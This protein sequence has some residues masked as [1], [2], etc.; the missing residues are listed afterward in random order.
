MLNQSSKIYEALNH[1]EMSSVIRIFE[2]GLEI[3]KL[4]N[5][6]TNDKDTQAC[7]NDGEMFLTF[8]HFR[9]IRD[10]S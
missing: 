8:L 9:N 5:I 2:K 3:E 4:E 10:L 1:V 7:I 6:A